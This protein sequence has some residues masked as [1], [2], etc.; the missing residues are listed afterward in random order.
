MIMKGQKRKLPSEDVDASDRS[1]PTWESQR[2]FVFSVSLSKYQ[3]GQELPEPSLRR[4][5]LIANTLR[6]INLEACRTPSIAR[7]V[8]QPHGSSSCGLQLK[9]QENIVTE[10]AAAKYH[11]AVT[12]AGSHSDLGSC[13][14]VSSDFFLDS[15]AS[16]SPAI[17]QS[18]ASNVPVCVDED[19][20]WGSMSTDPD[21]SLS[22]AISSILTAL[23][24]TIDG[25]PQS[26]PRAPLR[27]LENLVGPSEGNM[28]WV[29]Q[30]DRGFGGSWEQQ[31]EFR[32]CE[33]SMELMR[34]CYLSDLTMED[35]FQDIDT[36]LLERDMGTL[37]LRGSG[38]G[39]LAGDDL[40]RYLPPLSSSSNSFS[41]SLSQKCL[42][43]FSS[44][45][46]LSSSPSLSLVPSS[47]FSG[48]SYVRE[49]PELDHLMEILVES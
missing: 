32:V 35:L 38:G 18:S 48:Q 12:V 26:G 39:F 25:S 34:S 11:S 6:Q 30:S 28:T 36:S 45:S 44:F 19:E 37:G 5:V 27:S 41:L 16:M 42:P 17:C 49:A 14:L 46:P 13:P 47:P 2:Q 33:S 43:S 4:S 10:V 24:S 29:K 20:D 3:R 9:G 21:F 7:E 23:D 8:S 40:L 22:T 31:D 1:N 15:A